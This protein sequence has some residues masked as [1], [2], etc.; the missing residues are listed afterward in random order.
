MLQCVGSPVSS[1]GAPD[2]AAVYNRRSK[3]VAD[4]PPP[5]SPEV[6]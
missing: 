5:L 1:D 2:A 4:A 6:Q 3:G